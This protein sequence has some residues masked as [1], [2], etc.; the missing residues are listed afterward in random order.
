MK[1]FSNNCKRIVLICM[2]ILCVGSGCKEK[3]PIAEEI[4]YKEVAKDT[5]KDALL[6][7]IGARPNETQKQ[8]NMDSYIYNDSKY[9]SYSGK[10]TYCL[11]EDKVLF[12]KWE[13]TA[14]T[15]KKGEKIYDAVCKDL[16]KT[17]KKDTETEDNISK[18]STWK[19][20]DGKEK[21]VLYMKGEKNITISI[22]STE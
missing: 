9:L 15:K 7:N 17:C 14:D 22:T 21:R 19:D 2:V 4:S 5:S 6:N 20:S 16:S 18:A 11:V 8:D 3:L 12:S 1:K 10:M 13:T